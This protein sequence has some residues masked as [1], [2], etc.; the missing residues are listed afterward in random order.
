M[1]GDRKLELLLHMARSRPGDGPLLFLLG[2]LAGR[3][4]R[5]RFVRRLEDHQVAV[6]LVDPGVLVWPARIFR[7]RVGAQE[8]VDPVAMVSI[9]LERDDPIAVRLDLARPPAWFHEV[10]DDHGDAP[11]DSL[12]ELR[13]R[14]DLALDCFNECRR[15]LASGAPRREAELRFLLDLARREAAALGQALARQQS[16]HRPEGAQGRGP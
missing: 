14:V 11:A 16:Q 2:F 8:V 10:L 13:R 9:L 7:G 3:L 1:T 6:H 12:E 5:I 15:L 4:D